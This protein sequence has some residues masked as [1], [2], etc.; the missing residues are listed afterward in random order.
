MNNVYAR[1]QFFQKKKRKKENKTKQT[2]KQS[3]TMEVD[4]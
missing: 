1:S 4:I 3:K 2:N